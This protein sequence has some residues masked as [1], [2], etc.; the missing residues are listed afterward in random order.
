MA[1]FIGILFSSCTHISYDDLWRTKEVNMAKR[2]E[3]SVA[4]RMGWV[5]IRLRVAP[6]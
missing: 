4:Q 3:N 2:P 6:D 1:S 5:G